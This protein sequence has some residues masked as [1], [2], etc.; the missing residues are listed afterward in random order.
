MGIIAILLSLMFLSL[1]MQAAEKDNGWLY[2]GGDQ[3]G[4]HYSSVASITKENVNELDVAWV[5]RSGDMETHRDK[6]E[7]TS[8][9]STP[10]LLPEVAGESLVYCTPFNRVIALDPA[11]GQ[12][13]WQFDPQINLKVDFLQ[14]FAKIP[15]FG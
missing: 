3:G 2:Y 13:R 1:P 11:S 9:Q 12:Q 5:F 6:M 8:G 14:Y 10:I 15:L 7:N 4:R